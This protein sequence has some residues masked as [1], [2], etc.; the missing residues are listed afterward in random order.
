MLEALDVDTLIRAYSSLYSLSPG[1]IVIPYKVPT[2][3]LLSTID[4]R[5]SALTHCNYAL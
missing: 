4:T 1:Y 5:L 3:H 2:Y